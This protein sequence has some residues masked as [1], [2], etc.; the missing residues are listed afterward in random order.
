MDSLSRQKEN[1][2]EDLQK[3]QSDYTEIEHK[4]GKFAF[5]LTQADG[6]IEERCQRLQ[7]VLHVFFACPCFPIPTFFCG[8][9][10]RAQG[11]PQC[12]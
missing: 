3:L 1:L 10:A 8:R 5:D 4:C 7:Q 12:H 6:K 9:C 2:E 11:P